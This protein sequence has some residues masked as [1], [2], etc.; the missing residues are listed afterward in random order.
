MGTG[1]PAG[2]TVA[3]RQA[4]GREARKAAPRTSHRVWAAAADRPDPIALLRAQDDDR[5]QDLVPI[6]WGRMS[7]SPFAFYRG[8]AALMAAGLAPL[9]RTGLTV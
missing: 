3:E 9:P 1:K 8:S 7:G 4:A 5:M 2:L 6:R